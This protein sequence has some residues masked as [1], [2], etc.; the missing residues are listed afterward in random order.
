M[1]T[2]F[3]FLLLIVVSL[4]AFGDIPVLG[5][6]SAVKNDHIVKI[7]QVDKNLHLSL[8]DSKFHKYRDIGNS[9]DGKFKISGKEKSMMV[10]EDLQLAAWIKSRSLS[11]EMMVALMLGR[12]EYEGEADVIY[13]YASE[14]V[15]ALSC[16]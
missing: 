15:S 11:V 16:K 2:L 12:P 1:K 4:P 3:I 5:S 7:D 13:S 6:C 8:E 14:L 9:T 10:V